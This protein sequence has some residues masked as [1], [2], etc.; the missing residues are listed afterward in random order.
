MGYS[1]NEFGVFNAGMVG[2][3]CQ[4]KVNFIGNQFQGRQANNQSISR[5]ASQ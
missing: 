5:K 3:R 1:N 2:D 4:E